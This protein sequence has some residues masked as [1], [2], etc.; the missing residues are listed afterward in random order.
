MISMKDEP[1]LEELIPMLDDLKCS[2]TIYL[3]KVNLVQKK[4]RDENMDYTQIHYNDVIAPSVIECEKQFRSI[5]KDVITVQ[6]YLLDAKIDDK[7]VKFFKMRTDLHIEMIIKTVLKNLRTYAFNFSLERILKS[8]LAWY[9]QEEKKI[10]SMVKKYE[11]IVI[12]D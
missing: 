1:F 11:N 7:K 4:V 9:K 5:L 6:N 3:E 12:Q 8:F 10:N 2:I